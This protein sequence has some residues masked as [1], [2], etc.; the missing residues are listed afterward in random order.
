M[1]KERDKSVGW[2]FAVGSLLGH[3][4]QKET[5]IDFAAPQKIMAS[6]LWKGVAKAF[7]VEA[8]KKNNIDIS[9]HSSSQ[10][11]EKIISRNDLVFVMSQEHLD[12]FK[13]LYPKHLDKVYLLKKFEN[14]D[15]KDFNI[16]DPMGSGITVY[17]KIFH[18]IK[19]EIER[20]FSKLIKILENNE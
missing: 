14:P 8:S 16:I 12:F 20:I 15:S 1:A 19:N 18:E 4:A 7:A 6:T 13:N 10:I 5:L 17:E 9:S 2:K 11:N 3:I